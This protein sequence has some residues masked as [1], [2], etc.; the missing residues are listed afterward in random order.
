MLKPFEEQTKYVSREEPTIF[1]IPHLYLKLDTLLKAIMKNESQKY[2]SALL[3][4]ARKGH[5]KFNKYYKAMK[6]NDIYW[7]ACVLDPRI[8]ANWMKK[9]LD[10]HKEIIDRVKQFIKDSY[11]LEEELPESQNYEKNMEMEMLEEYGLAFSGDDD[12]ER[13]FDLL[14]VQYLS[15]S[16]ENYTQWVL[17]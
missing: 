4:A 12:V 3:A 1:R 17:N 13:Y 2:D 15:N 9:N 5:D 8:K 16:K 10:N 6:A 11:P 7:I 14:V